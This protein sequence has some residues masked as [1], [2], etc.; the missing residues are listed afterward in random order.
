[1][2]LCVNPHGGAALVCCGQLL[3]EDFDTTHFVCPK[4]GT[5]F[6]EDQVLDLLTQTLDVNGQEYSERGV[7]FH[8]D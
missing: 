7:G 3:V 2:T 1:M 4:C 6:I 5:R 8:V